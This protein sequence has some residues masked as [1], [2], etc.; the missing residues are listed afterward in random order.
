MLQYVI[1]DKSRF[2]TFSRV[3]R[4]MKE[5]IEAMR[6]LAFLHSVG[7]QDLEVFSDGDIYNLAF[8]H[9]VGYRD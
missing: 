3:S 2:P 9:S 5:K 8:L 6:N 1:A 4:P 7:Y